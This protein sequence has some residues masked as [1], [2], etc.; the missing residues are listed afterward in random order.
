[1]RR[2]GGVSP[3]PITVAKCF[4]FKLKH[5]VKLVAL[6]KLSDEHLWA[7]EDPERLAAMQRAGTATRRATRACFTTLSSTTRR[8]CWFCTG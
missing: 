5:I 6:G 2:H 8:T 4:D 1:M 7:V 3:E